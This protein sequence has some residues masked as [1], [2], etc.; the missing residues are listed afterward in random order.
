MAVS[1]TLLTQRGAVLAALDEFERLGR[2]TFL[3]VHGF[4][5][6]RA[7]F[8][9]DPRSGQWCDSKAIV[10]VAFGI[11]HPQHGPVAPSDFSGGEATVA[12][13]LRALGF[14]VVRR[15]ESHGSEQAWSAEEVAAVVA[16]YLAMLTLDLAGQR[17][18]KSERRRALVARLRGR[19]E[20]AVEFKH[21][22]ISA[23]MLEL[24]FPSLRGYPPRSNYQRLLADEVVAQLPRM[25]VLEQAALKAV[26]TPAV[27]PDVADFEGVMTT[28]P[29]MSRRLSAWEESPLYGRAPIKRDYLER[30]ARNRALGDAGELFALRFE[31]W[32][33][34]RAGAS[35]L[36]QKVEH[37]SKQRGDGLGYDILSFEPDGQER[38]VEVKTTAFGAATP[39][40]VSDR[41]LRCARERGDRYRL[42]RLYEFRDEP[43]LFELFGAIEAHCRLDP[44]SYAA[45]F[46]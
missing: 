24:G 14:E 28:P 25:P 31:R 11:E 8:V 33:L 9:V 41:E 19:S 26:E 35:Q 12:E 36:A 30:E 45:S 23:V 40:F 17:F 42:L 10:G 4:R 18:N 37:V 38:Y 16:D 1:L 7:Y 22:N 34:E 46:H 32:R 6:A 5:P 3:E 21:C 13:R 27:E 29:E 43:R 20:S 2:D 44:V 39:F 15:G